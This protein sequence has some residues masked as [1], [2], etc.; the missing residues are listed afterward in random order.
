MGVNRLQHMVKAKDLPLF[1]RGVLRG[2]ET[3]GI[4]CIEKNY[5]RHGK[6]IPGT[7]L[8]N[9]KRGGKENRP[10]INVSKKRKGL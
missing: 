8:T 7:D 2:G 6:K 5:H 3:E 9:P 4:S 1:R 10:E